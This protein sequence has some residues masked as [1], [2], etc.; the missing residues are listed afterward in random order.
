[1]PSQE[2]SVTNQTLGEQYSGA[3]TGIA[4]E[5]LGDAKK[6]TEEIAKSL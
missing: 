4:L 6:M 5:L 3:W 2:V 1:M